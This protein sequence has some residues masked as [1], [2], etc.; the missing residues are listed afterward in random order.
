MAGLTI[1]STQDSD[2]QKQ[3]E[4]EC[5]KKKYKLASR[6]SDDSSQAAMVIIDHKTGNVVGCTGGLGEKTTARSFN[7][8]TQSVRQTGSAIKPIAVLLPAID[9]KIITAATIFDD[10]EQ[11]FENNY[12]PT[13]YSKSLGKI[14]V[15]RAVES[16]Q[17]IPFVE[18]MEKLKP[19]NSIKYLEK[20]E[21]QH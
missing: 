13:D 16:S 19:K 11:D 2:I 20:W 14:T 8:A 5:S 6:N 10:T 9:K 17:N 15:R 3:M 21:L 7:R 18:I 1:Y 4:T 12:H